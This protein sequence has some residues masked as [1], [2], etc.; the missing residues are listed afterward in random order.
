LQ[1]LIITH[2]PQATLTDLPQ[3][4][5]SVKLNRL[6][7]KNFCHKNT[8]IN[9]Q[10]LTITNCEKLE[11]IELPTGI[12]HLNLSG[13]IKLNRSHIL[14]L[15]KLTNLKSLNISE[16]RLRGPSNVS[17]SSIFHAFGEFMISLSA[18]LHGLKIRR[19]ESAA[20]GIAQSCKVA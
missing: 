13:C 8:L 3:T 20:T 19:F 11:N 12:Q 5:V 1:N 6:L 15:Q 7:I 4:L 2:H 14:H 16:L 18:F 17:M 9:L 10:T